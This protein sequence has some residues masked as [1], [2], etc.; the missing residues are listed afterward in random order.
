VSARAAGRVV[1]S[2]GFAR[3]HRLPSL[4]DGGSAIGRRRRALTVSRRRRFPA[5]G[6]AIAVSAVPA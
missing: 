6:L 5:D 4:R 2:G 3:D 1:T